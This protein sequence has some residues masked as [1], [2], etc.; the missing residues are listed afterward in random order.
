MTVSLRASL[1]RSVR[2]PLRTGIHPAIVLFVFENSMIIL[3][4]IITIIILNKNR[5]SYFSL[6]KAFGQIKNDGPVFPAA[7]GGHQG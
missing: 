4:Y 6:K 3:I 1:A 5:F 2:F 7:L